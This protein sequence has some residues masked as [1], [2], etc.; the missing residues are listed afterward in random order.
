MIRIEEKKEFV[1]NYEVIKRQ[2]NDINTW[3][4]DLRKHR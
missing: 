2:I 4:N 3:H 1:L